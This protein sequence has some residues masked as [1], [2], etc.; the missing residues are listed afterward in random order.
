MASVIRNY[1]DNGKISFLKDLYG[2]FDYDYFDS[3]VK[4][5]AADHLKAFKTNPTSWFSSPGRIE[6]LG[7][8]TDHNNGEVLCASISLDTLSC[9]NKTDDG[10]IRLLSQGYPMIVVDTKDIDVHKEEYST[11][12]ALVRGVAAYYKQHGFKVGGFT[13]CA[14]STVFKGA[15]V[16]SSASFELL[17]A[18]ILN[19]LYNDGIVDA[20]DK[21]QAAHLAE[22][23]YF[24]KPCGLLDQCAISLGGVSYIDFFDGQPHPS[25]LSSIPD[26]SVILVNAGGDHSSLTDQ[27]AA[28]R[29]EMN[30]VAKYF[31]KEVLRDV[32]EQE[33]YDKLPKLRK[34]LSGRAILRAIHFFEENHRVQQGR[35]AIECENADNLVKAINASGLSSLC[36]LQNCYP[37]GDKVQSIPSAVEILKRIDGIK[38]ARV[39][40][41]GFAGTAIAF[42]DKNKINDIRYILDDAFGRENYF[43]V[44]VRK[45]GACQIPFDF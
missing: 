19:C 15:G 40:G 27:Y 34:S 17:I 7:N 30:A 6:I 4:T 18:E 33:F 26:L 3:R 16:S 28:I 32:D 11:S 14:H 37:E 22:S 25:R 9:V 43:I 39:H 24:N 21:A 20:L 29:S 31:G 45:Y 38:A 12:S 23:V 42:A 1:D 35:K 36:L 8:H 10:I 44:N 2:E 13:A 5:L 41:G